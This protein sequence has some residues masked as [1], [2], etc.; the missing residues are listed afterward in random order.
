VRKLISILLLTCLSLTFAGYHLVFYI[1]RAAL[2]SEMKAFLKNEKN[3]AGL[4][5]LR[6]TSDQL[7]KLEW[8]DD[9]EFL[10]DGK[11]YDVVSK[12]KEGNEIII[13]CFPDEKETNLLNE[14]QKTHDRNTSHTAIVQLITSQFVLPGNYCL[15]QPE[16]IIKK[17]FAHY[18][19]FLN[20]P[21]SAIIPHPPDA[22]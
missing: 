18:S 16:K 15:P 2:K 8:E 22:C 11:M 3:P 4:A 10:F 20:N 17:N 1:Q 14:Y 5:E 9:E 21:A 19:F 6:F 13:L 12:K 7:I